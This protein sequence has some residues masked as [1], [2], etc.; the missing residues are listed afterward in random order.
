MTAKERQR[1]WYEANKTRLIEYES[2]KKVQAEFT[3]IEI[4]D[5]A[6]YYE[7]LPDDLRI[8]ETC[9]QCGC[10]GTYRRYSHA[11]TGELLPKLV[12]ECTRPTCDYKFSAIRHFKVER[13]QI[14]RT[15]LTQVEPD[16]SD[17]LE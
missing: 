9:P 3:S 12:G 1:I 7:L 15:E 10:L 11:T 5:C 6:K 16:R 2:Q 13:K 14:I 8:N 4:Q 17:G